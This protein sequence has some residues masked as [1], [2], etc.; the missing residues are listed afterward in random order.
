MISICSSVYKETDS[1]EIFVRSVFGNASKP[2]DVEMII[3]NDESYEPTEETLI[4]LEEEFKQL[5]HID[6]PK[7]NRI[8]FFKRV[9]DFYDSAKIFPPGTTDPMREQIALYESGELERI[10]YPSGG[11]YNYA[12]REAKGDYMVICPSDYLFMCDVSMLERFINQIP[13]EHKELRFDWYDFTSLE[14]YPDILN[15]LKTSKD[16]RSITKEWMKQ[17]WDNNLMMVHMQH[18]ARIINS[19]LYPLTRGFDDRWFIRALH[20]DLF[21]LASEIYAP[22]P[23][24]IM[25][26]A[27]KD[28]YPFVGPV[29]GRPSEYHYLS[30]LYMGWGELHDNLKEDIKHFLSTG[31][32]KYEITD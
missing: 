21:N 11:R 4:K 32:G 29:R 22:N 8:E 19:T 30:P 25:D 1:L 2:D 6:F 31:R 15:I 28:C 13:G 9:V 7:K 27:M 14:P 18:G 12:C 16:I 10:W 24:R 17:A 3:V 5:R 20:E 23:H 26:Y